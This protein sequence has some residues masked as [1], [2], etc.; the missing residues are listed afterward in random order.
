MAERLSAMGPRQR[1][2]AVLGVVVV[3]TAGI[4]FLFL[5]DSSGPEPFAGPTRTPRASQT[6]PTRPTVVPTPSPSG[7]P[8][9]FDGFGGKDPFL[10]LVGE[11]PPPANGSPGPEPSPGSTGG[12]R[13]GQRVEL[14]DIFTQGNTRY[15]SV[16]VDN[17]AYTVRSGQTFAGSYKVLSLSSSCGTFAFG[18]ERF[19]LCIGQEVLK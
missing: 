2:L 3:L 19:T 14:I 1:L 11:S 12:P 18:D 17:K 5:R 4:Y 10:P 13:G 16:E 8:E 7:A 9:T 6:S 15:A